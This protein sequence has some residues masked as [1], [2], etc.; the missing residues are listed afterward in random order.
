MKH[1]HPIR[2]VAR[3]T[4]LSPHLIRMWE[5]RYGAVEPDRTES[6][7]RLYSDEDIERLLLLKVATEA[8]ESIGQIAG[9][10]ERDLLDLVR[11][12]RQEE[13][14][15]A[16]VEDRLSAESYLRSCLEAVSKF[17][18]QLFESRLLQASAVLGQ[19]SLLNDLL[20]PLLYRIGE[21]WSDGSL[22][23]AHEHLASTVVRSLLGSM[24]SAIR[25]EDNAP[26]FIATTPAGQFHEFGALMASVTAASLGWRVMYLGPNM[27]VED[28]AAATKGTS[29]RVVGLS[30]VYPPDD[31]RLD[32]ELRKLRHLVG[33]DV[34]IVAGGRAV[35]G[36]AAILDELGILKINDLAE[37]RTEL[38]NT[39]Q[40]SALRKRDGESAAKSGGM[41]H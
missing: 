6:N 14:A 7:R 41:I 18:S 10:S 9:L 40:A 39:R 25:L 29:A 4:G 30:L 19:Q 20:I 21:M 13:P 2:V 27:P 12:T 11:S 26:R 1:K 3:R 35:P 8:G 23:V 5:R 28:I 33:E 24:M 38:E 22:R 16:P 36:Y 15:L 32:L 31:R 34:V 17:D 37:L